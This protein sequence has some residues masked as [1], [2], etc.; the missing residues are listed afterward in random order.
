METSHSFSA[1]E[2]AFQSA[3]RMAGDPGSADI[4]DFHARRAFVLHSGF[5]WASS[6]GIEVGPLAS[7]VILKSMSNVTYVDHADTPSL[8]E[9]YRAVAGV[10]ISKIV[11]VDAVW[12][13]KTL[14]EMME[15]RK[16]DYIVASHVLE[17]V[18]DLITWLEEAAQLLKPNGQLRIVMPDKRFS[19]D[20]TRDETRVADI[21]TA[22]LIRSRR[23]QVRDILDSE[24]HV[25]P[26]VDGWGIYEGRAT[27]E[28]VKPVNS[29]SRALEFA[30]SARDCPELYIDVHCWVFRARQFAAMMAKLSEYGLIHLACLNMSDAVWPMLEY[31]A[32]M[33]PCYDQDQVTRSWREV[34]D[35]LPDNLLGSAAETYAGREADQSGTNAN[36]SSLSKD[37]DELREL[38][39]VSQ[40]K[41]V[42]TASRFIELEAALQRAT[43]ELQSI[44][45]SRSWRLVSLLRDLSRRRL[46]KQT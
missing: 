30:R 7:P 41:E 14:L 4:S 43:A 29:F 45:V 34:A 5:N 31:Y 20:A 35:A 19:F 16:Q 27:L 32:F 3:I 9:K 10:D 44:K 15:G 8:C 38:L 42:Q 23:P 1:T 13:E 25:A 21:L 36:A 11:N 40:S 6:C 37:C 46:S 18:P 17:H 28:H 24:L 22:W 12:G 26:S 33:Y 39:R 2:F